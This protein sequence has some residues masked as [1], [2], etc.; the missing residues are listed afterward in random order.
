MDVWR[1]NHFLKIWNPPI[2]TTIY[3]WKFQVPGMSACTSYIVRCL[4]QV[5]P[6]LPQP[7]RRSTRCTP[8]TAAA[9]KNAAHALRLRNTDRPTRQSQ[10]H[11]SNITSSRVVLKK[12]NWKIEAESKQVH[13]LQADRGENLLQNYESPKNYVTAIFQFIFFPQSPWS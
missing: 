5:L 2:E 12:N 8:S 4:I 3:K 10:K 6:P 13:L 1:N 11:H 7:L 9:G